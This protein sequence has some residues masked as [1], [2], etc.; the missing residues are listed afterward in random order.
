MVI[1]SIERWAWTPESD[2]DAVAGLHAGRVRESH[3]LEVKRLIPGGQPGASMI[4]K[5]MCGLSNDSSTF[6]IGVAEDPNGQHI[7]H[8]VPLQGLRERVL[9]VAASC[10]ARITL[11]PMTVLEDPANAG[12][13]ILLVYV[14]ASMNAPH[15]TPDGRYYGRDEARSYP[16]A[17]AEVQR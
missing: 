14:P 1:V 8:S 5:A 16:M 17:D 4:A 15:M 7:P 10:D 9:S 3:Y 11:P 6:V 2:A 13:G 12:H